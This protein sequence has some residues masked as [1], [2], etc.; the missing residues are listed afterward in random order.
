MSCLRSVSLIIPTQLHANILDCTER[1]LAHPHQPGFFEWSESN[2]GDSLC[3]GVHLSVAVT[4]RLALAET[5]WVVVVVHFCRVGLVVQSHFAGLFIDGAEDWPDRCLVG[6]V[7]EHRRPFKID[8]RW[9]ISQPLIAP[10]VG[11]RED[12]YGAVAAGDG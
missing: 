5:A 6:I 3:G 2:A 10:L 9:C 7:G 12:V 4:R 8:R 11:G 1:P